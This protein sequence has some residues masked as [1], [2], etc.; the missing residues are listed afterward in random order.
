MAG[1]MLYVA[2]GRNS[3]Q[4][5]RG[6]SWLAEGNTCMAVQDQNNPAARLRKLLNQI[7]AG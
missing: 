2:P 1:L 5:A 7:G 3:V 6:C 4:A